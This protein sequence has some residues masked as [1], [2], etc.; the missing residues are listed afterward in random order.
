MMGRTDIKTQRI[1]DVGH[2]TVSS[3]YY[4]VVESD[5]GHSY[6]VNE[7]MLFGNGQSSIVVGTHND[8]DRIVEFIKSLF[9]FSNQE[10]AIIMMFMK[11]RQ[12]VLDEVNS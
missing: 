7:T 5:Y 10:L 12:D 2:F 6:I 4:R 8:H 1:T 9:D 11:T 3:V